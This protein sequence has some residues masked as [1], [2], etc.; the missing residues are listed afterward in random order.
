MFLNSFQS[1]IFPLK[2]KKTPGWGSKIR[3]PKQMLQ[4][5]P[6]TLAQLKS[7]NRSEHLKTK[8][9]KLFLVLSK[10]NH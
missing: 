3:T 5:L 1:E 6:I 4:R 7:E 10:T 9:E 8:L 2:K